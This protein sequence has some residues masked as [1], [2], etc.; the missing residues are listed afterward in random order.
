MRGI[1]SDGWDMRRGR[2]V[3]TCRQHFLED[4]RENWRRMELSEDSVLFYSL[5]L[6]MGDNTQWRKEAVGRKREKHGL[7]D[8]LQMRFPRKRAGVREVGF[9]QE[10]ELLLRWIPF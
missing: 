3:C 9:G 6:K 4:R 5:P 7:G 8:G 1:R 2:Q 10:E